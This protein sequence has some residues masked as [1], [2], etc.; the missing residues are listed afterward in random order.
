M[1]LN[2]SVVI[3]SLLVSSLSLAGCGAAA[4]VASPENQNTNA[5]PVAN[6]AP[7]KGGMM[8]PQTP[9]ELTEAQKTQLK[10][11]EEVHQPKILTFDIT[12]GSFYFVPNQMKV[13]KGDT[14][15][16]VFTNAGGMHN[17][18]LDEFNVKI[19]P[20]QGGEMATAEFVA[21]KAGT[22]EYYCGIGQHRKLGQKGTLV[23]E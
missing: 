3:A 5:M 16:I 22:F 7:P 17:F 11:G 4:P 20:T 18:V 10:A 1:S 21:D 19:N 6:M 15:K 13:K 2:R 9:P 23:V 8:E 12:A 14:V